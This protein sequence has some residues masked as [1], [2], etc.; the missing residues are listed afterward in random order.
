MVL[1][2]HAIMNELIIQVMGNWHLIMAVYLDIH[3]EIVVAR[4]IVE[5]KW[6]FRVDCNTA[7]SEKL[8]ACPSGHECLDA[9]LKSGKQ[10]IICTYVI[11]RHARKDTL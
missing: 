1:V 6:V 8:G 3:R 7:F 5:C 11:H 9:L 4:S 10:S 2:Q